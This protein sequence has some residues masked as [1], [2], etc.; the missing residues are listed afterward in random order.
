MCDPAC[1]LRIFHCCFSPAKDDNVDVLF[2]HAVC[3]P[4]SVI[5]LEGRQKN[6]IK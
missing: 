3:Y 6:H 5:D 4:S 2:S 1:P